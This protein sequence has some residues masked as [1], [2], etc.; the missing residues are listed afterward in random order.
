MRGVLSRTRPDAGR[1]GPQLRLA[2]GLIAAGA[3][4]LQPWPASGATNTPGAVAE[5]ISKTFVFTG[6]VQTDRIPAGVTSVHVVA[7]GGPGAGGTGELGGR[8]G[9]GAQVTAQVPISASGQTLQILVGGGG[10][11]KGGWNGGGAATA[12]AGGG[13]GASEVRSGDTAASDLVVAAGGGGGGQSVTN[14]GGAGGNG[15]HFGSPGRDG[16]PARGCIGSG[17][18]PGTLSGPGLGGYDFCGTRDGKD[19]ARGL[20][21]AGGA[22]GADG[23]GGGAGYFGGGGGGAAGEPGSRTPY[24]RAAGGGGGG[25][26]WA[27]PSAS[28]VKWGLA[29]RPF[30]ELSYTAPGG[31]VGGGSG[32]NGSVRVAVYAALLNRPVCALPWNPSSFTAKPHGSY[33]TLTLEAV[34]GGHGGQVVLNGE[35]LEPGTYTWTITARGDGP[36]QSATGVVTLTAS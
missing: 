14:A 34:P 19:G 9:L 8:G 16:Q 11:A 6:A 5:L 29:G 33:P 12:R 21:G 2:A 25:S 15:G 30:V 20:G 36:G 23:G 4:A 3:L 24:P 1:G 13:G 26:S 7:A 31:I 22:G 28:E 35:A 18:D 27:E 32:C 10:T 17:G